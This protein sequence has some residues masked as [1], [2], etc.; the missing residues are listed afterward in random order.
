MVL[1]IA[2]RRI[3]T[4]HLRHLPGV[5]AG[6]VD[7]GFGGDGALFGDHPP[8][9]GRQGA[10]V[11]HPIAR[12][13][14][15]TQVAGAAGH[16]VA[17][18]GGVRMA[19]IAGPGPGQN[20]IDVDEGIEPPNLLDVDDLQMEADV[21]GDAAHLFKPVQVPLAEGE[22]HTAAA[23][24]T[25]ELAGQFLQPP[26][27]GDAVFM[28]LGEVVVA[29]E[30]GALAGGVPSGA[31]GELTLLHKQHVGAALQR[32][33]IEQPHAHD[34]AADD[35]DAYLILHGAPPDSAVNSTA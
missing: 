13:D 10:D 4:D 6:G 35:D 14:L 33:M 29:N 30:V 7:D 15:R 32:K 16:G 25:D 27:Q 21:G 17:Q 11:Q 26:V 1:D 20:A 28:N 19:V 18:A 22:A 9:P 31:G 23:V 3:G 2:D 5:A 24:P 34:A 12:D 8:L